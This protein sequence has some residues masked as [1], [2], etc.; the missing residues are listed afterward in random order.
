M[1]EMESA[2]AKTKSL[3]EML[4]KKAVLFVQVCIY[5]NPYFKVH[6]LKFH[7]INA[8]FRLQSVVLYYILLSVYKSRFSLEAK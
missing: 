8:L 3:G 5:N 2:A 6:I 7:S 4:S 1:I